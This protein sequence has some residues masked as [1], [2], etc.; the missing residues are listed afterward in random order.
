MR[1]AV[2]ASGGLDSAVLLAELARES[3]VWPLYVSAGLPWEQ[4]E[5]RALE[6]FIAALASESVQPVTTLHVPARPLYGNHWSL[7]NEQIPDA[8]SPDEA[9]YLPGRNIL[10]LGLC[11]VWCSVHDVQAMAIGSLGGNPFPDGTPAFFRDY[12]RVLSAGLAHPLELLTP[13]RGL[14]KHELIQRASGLPLEL[15]LTCLAPRDG[16]HCGACNKCEERRQAFL[17]SGIA[18]RTR[19]RNEH[20]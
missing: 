20:A 16:A 9:V 7:T 17:R 8:A 11:A 2:L 14:H 6:R 13:Y 12:A 19:Y 15:T 18:D 10:L 3:R 4:D 5:L 1:V